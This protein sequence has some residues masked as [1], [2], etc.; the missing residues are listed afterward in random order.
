MVRFLDL[1]SVEGVIAFDSPESD[2]HLAHSG[3]TRLAPDVAPDEVAL[4]APCMTYKFGVLGLQIVGAKAGVRLPAAVPDR[5]AYFNRYLD[6]I[7]EMVEQRVFTTGPDL[8]TTEADFAPLRATT[9]YRGAMQQ[10]VDGVPFEEIVTGYGLA[11][12]ADAATGGV[13]GLTFAIEGFGKVGGGVAREAARRG[14]R[15]TA[16]STLAGCVVSD[17]GFDV[18]VLWAAR[19]EHGDLFVHHLGV[20]VLSRESLFGQEVDVLVPGTRPGSVDEERARTVRARH[21][22]PAANA[23]YTAEALEVLRGRGVAAHAD[24]LV[25]AGGAYGYNHPTARA[26]ASIEELTAGLDAFMAAVVPETLEHPGGP[27]EGACDVAERFI[28]SWRGAGWVA[29]RP[30]PAGA[31]DHRTAI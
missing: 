15:I 28:R 26:A 12:A 18:D 14:A 4:L 13:A 10:N 21:I 30:V 20:P 23:P 27:Y 22:V 9:T 11:A 31:P 3:G 2:A 25:N 6:E 5:T 29:H 19:R 24:F 8:G 1:R 7:R 16:V 17:D